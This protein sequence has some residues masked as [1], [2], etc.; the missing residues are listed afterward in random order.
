V[1][2]DV[3]SRELTPTGTLRTTRLILKRGALPRWAP[4]GIVAKAESWILEES[5]VDPLG[6]SV[7]CATRN[8]DH[9]KVMSAREEITLKPAPDGSAR[10]VHTSTVNIVSRFGWGLT[11]QIEEH[12]VSK[13][14]AN[15]QK[16][17]DG[18]ALV[19]ALLRQQPMALGLSGSLS[20]AAAA[21]TW[22]AREASSS[23][24]D[25]G[26]T[27]GSTVPGRWASVKQW[28]RKDA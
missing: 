2:C 18:L 10:T 4:R 7:R 23:R 26:K 1:S 3:I 17:R 5:E 28:F 13:F 19:M 9:V 16:S 25:D 27:L 6:R 24:T 22:R 8:L 11:R 14:A 12:G 15:L 20:S 21:E